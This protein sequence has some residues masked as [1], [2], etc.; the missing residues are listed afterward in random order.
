MKIFINT[1]FLT[2]FLLFSLI[3]STSIWAGGDTSTGCGVGW[4]VTKSMTTIGATT[5]ASTNGTFSN[6]LAM[7]SGTSGC[8]RHSIVMNEKMGLHFIAANYQNILQDLSQGNG[9]YLLGLSRTMGCS[10]N[11]SNIFST[12]ARS[13]FSEIFPIVNGQE[14]PERSLQSLKKV[15]KNNQILV[16]NCNILG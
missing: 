1:I 12:E 6:T 14:N 2:I 11:V 3:L 10:D 16:S 15:I 13:H 5:R 7:T 9:E 8:A 4:Y